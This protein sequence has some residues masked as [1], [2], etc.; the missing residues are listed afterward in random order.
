LE[1]VVQ[2]DRT[3]QGRSYRY[4]R[5]PLEILPERYNLSGY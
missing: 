3:P 5:Y 1:R 4:H 2:I